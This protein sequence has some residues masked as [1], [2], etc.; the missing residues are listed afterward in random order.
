[1]IF[2][3]LAFSAAGSTNQKQYPNA[4][5]QLSAEPSM[6]C[7]RHSGGRSPFHPC[8]SL[9]ALLSVMIIV[10]ST[11]GLLSHLADA[12]K[13]EDPLA[14]RH[15]RHPATSSSLL[16]EEAIV[17]VGQDYF[18]NIFGKVMPLNLTNGTIAS[19]YNLSHGSRNSS[20]GPHSTSFASLA[21][22]RFFYRPSTWFRRRS[23]L[24]L[25]D[26]LTR[27]LSSDTRAAVQSVRAILE[28]LDTEHGI[29]DIFALHSVHSILLSGLAL[30][31][32]QG[33]SASFSGTR[34]LSEQ[35]G[36]KISFSP[37]DH[38]LLEM[39]AHNAKFAASAYGW[40]GRLALSGRL[41]FGNV[42]ALLSRTGI[43]R[44][45][46][47]DS[48]WRSR[49]NRPAYFI[50][51]DVRRKSLVLCV[52]GTWSARDFLTD[53]VANG[54]DFDAGISGDCGH[55]T[56]RCA[57]QGMVQGAW[58][59]DKMTRRAIKNELALNA[60]YDLIILGHSLGGGI[61]AV[62]GTMW[63]DAFPS[64]TVLSYGCPCVG[65]LDAEPTTNTAVI[66]VVAE[67]DP[68]SCLR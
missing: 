48:N 47:V 15:P 56:R 64:L 41:H 62:L 11:F 44:A 3:G 35:N 50:V 60:D 27:L 31:R 5:N 45:D 21:R 17:S 32:L 19:A 65:P 43:S 59:I 53:L 9:H 67:G 58:Q 24:L 1:M 28:R 52:R 10:S 66:S 8:L 57:H 23:S 37:V 39:L 49:A 61:A 34:L 18:V 20:E 12:I 46:I 42:R 14:S 51:R 2:H 54:A 4:W 38:D 29:L 13:S 33:A 7:K 55:G 30:S 22:R 25:D 68:F 36:T 6:H 26:A 63:R 16:S 40:K